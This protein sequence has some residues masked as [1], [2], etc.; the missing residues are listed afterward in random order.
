MKRRTFISSVGLA[1][2]GSAASGEEKSGKK[3]RIGQI[4][5]K[6]GHAEGKM[7]S[8]RKLNDLFDVVGLV[9]EDADLWDRAKG[10]RG[11][12]DLARRTEADLLGDESVQAVVVETGVDQ[13]VPTARRALEAGKAVFM[14]K[15]AGADGPLFEDTIRLAR[16][17]ELHFQMG[18]MLRFS[19]GI[20]FCRRAMEAG[21]LGDIF[22]I[23]A[24]M[25]KTIGKE[26]RLE[27]ARYPGGAMFELG[28]HLIDAVVLL[29][30]APAEVHPVLRKMR[31]DQDPLAD[32]TLAVLQYPKASAVV[33]SSLVD[34]EGFKRRQFV[35][36]G[37]HGTIEMRPLE[38]TSAL[39]TLD[40]DR[41][42]FRK[43]TQTV[44]LTG[45]SGRYDDEFREFAAVLKGEKEPFVSY[46]HDLEVH[47]AV[48]AA[49]GM[50]AE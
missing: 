18:Y 25:G 50:L 8:M 49:S 11:F 22:E 17:K 31:P 29:L 33:R 44:R 28:C 30:G 34:V 36:C 1:L 24:V 47:R 4:G 20:Q 45:L 43:G 26:D 39:L 12:R 27:L 37:E 19:P 42:E 38:G 41:E 5:T 2:A 32:N 15:P 10:M 35:L 40:R 3:I 7:A 14:D 9:E 46:D 48:L 16:E 23:H 6:H 21:W 13:L